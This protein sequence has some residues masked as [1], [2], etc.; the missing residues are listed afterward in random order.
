MKLKI[1][2]E[3]S[4]VANNIPH[5]YE[6]SVV[7]HPNG[8]KQLHIGQW[9]DVLPVLERYPGSTVTK[10]YPPKPPDTVDVPHIKIKDQE[11]PMQQI[12]PESK[13]EPIDL[14]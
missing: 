12:L 11:L 7:G 8:I 5:Y 2:E 14:K 3:M 1:H 10:I 13:L 9:R 4:L 6:V